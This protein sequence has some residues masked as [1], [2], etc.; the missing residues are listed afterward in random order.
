[1]L[2]EYGTYNIAEHYIAAIEYGDYTGLC[3]GEETELQ[4]FLDSLPPGPWTWNYG[5]EP[6]FTEDCV[7]GLKANCLECTLYVY[8][9][10]HG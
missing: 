2:T 3:D 5:S 8:G 7:S 10:R 4:S 9:V 6:E 1:M